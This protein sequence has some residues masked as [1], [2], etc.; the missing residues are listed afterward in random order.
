[1]VLK[2]DNVKY[3]AFCRKYRRQEKKLILLSNILKL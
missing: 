3:Y 2:T 1:M